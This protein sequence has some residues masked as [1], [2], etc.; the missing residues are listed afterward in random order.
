MKKISIFAAI[1]LG[2]TLICGCSDD[3]DTSKTPEQIKQEVASMD[4]AAIQ[5]KVDAYKKAMDEKAAEIKAESEKL[6]AQLKKDA[7]KLGK[8]DVGKKLGNLLSGESVQSEEAKKI[9]AKIADLKAEA[10]KIGANLKAYAE[11]L[12]K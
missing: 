4:T 2:A 11:G 3:V 7:E 1:A 5:K 9:E 10:E 6:A 8:E 12:K